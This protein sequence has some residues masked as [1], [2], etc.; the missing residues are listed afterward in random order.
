M[1][2]VS[3]L[4]LHNY[5]F[6]NFAEKVRLVLGYK[7]LAWRSVTIP[8]VM[9]KPMLTPLTG[10][11]R[12]TPVLQVGA[13][14]WCDTRLILRELE[15]RQP[16][17][18]LYPPACA[19]LADAVVYWAEHRVVRPVALYMSGMNQDVLPPA[20]AADRARMRGLPEPAPE[21]VRRA[22]Q[23]HAPLVRV[24]FARI[25]QMLS[26][27]RAWVAGPATSEADFAVYHA[28]WLLTAPSPL[29]AHEVAAFPALTAFMARMRAFGHG[30]SI[31]MDAAEALQV[32]RDAVPA[33]PRASA[34]FPEDPPLGAVVRVRA[35]DHAQD[36]ITGELV[37][38]DADEIALRRSDPQA[39]DVVVHFPRVGYELRA[40]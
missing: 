12:R 21:V 11:Y 1:Q 16:L 31:D 9:P 40:A 19:A 28:V 5:D 37:Q 35:D 13:D 39:G 36:P 10:G 3:E 2:T 24:L 26:E 8:P 6:S 25:E 20:L 18:T 23:R 22:A 7:G 34:P 29:L 33:A 17:P 14:V 4:I 38:I 30:R 27:G 32:A 15:R